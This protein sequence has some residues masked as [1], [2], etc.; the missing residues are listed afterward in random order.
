MVS[1]LRRADAAFLLPRFEVVT[2]GVLIFKRSDLVE[3]SFAL[4]TPREY[5]ETAHPRAVQ[6]EMV[7]SV[8]G[9]RKCEVLDSRHGSNGSGE[10]DLRLP[11][12]QVLSIQTP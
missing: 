8:R 4:S 10:D 11:L 1:A 5:R 2:T 12:D 7:E 6:A 9:R 3:S